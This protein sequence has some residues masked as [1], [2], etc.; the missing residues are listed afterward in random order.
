M[1][2]EMFIKYLQKLPKKAEVLISV[3]V[4]TGDDDAGKRAFANEFLDEHISEPTE[5]ILLFSGFLN[6]G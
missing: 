4:S 2:V 1:T 6:N 5:V 3:D